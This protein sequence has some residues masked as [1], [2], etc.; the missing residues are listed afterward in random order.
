MRFDIHD[1]DEISHSIIDEA[2]QDISVGTWLHYGFVWDIAGIAGASDTMRL[3]R[4]GVMVAS[5][6]EA[7]P[8]IWAG[9]EEVRVYGHHQ[10][11]RLNQ[12]MLYLDNLKVWDEPLT[13]FSHRFDEDWVP[14]PTSLSL[15]ALGA[16]V[17]AARRF[18]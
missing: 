17:L 9:S 6:D 1:G 13:D 14:E 7:I 18:A 4:D 15:L 12:S 10:F 2:F 11:G 5:T 8:G 16:L 3:Y